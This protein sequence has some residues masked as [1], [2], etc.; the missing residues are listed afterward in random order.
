MELNPRGFKFKSILD[1]FT[2]DLLL[3][4]HE[5]LGD[6][7]VDMDGLK[8]HILMVLSD[9]PAQEISNT[10]K[11]SSS[12]SKQL[13]RPSYVKNL[14]FRDFSATKDALWHPF[15]LPASG[16]NPACNI[17]LHDEAINYLTRVLE[18]RLTLAQNLKD[19]PTNAHKLFASL[20]HHSECHTDWQL[21]KVQRH[22]DYQTAQE[23][24]LYFR[25]SAQRLAELRNKLGSGFGDISLRRREQY[26]PIWLVVD[27]C[28][29]EMPEE[30]SL[31][32]IISAL[33]LALHPE[34]MQDPE[35]QRGLVRVLDSLNERYKLLRSTGLKPNDWLPRTQPSI[36]VLRE[37]KK[38][39]TAAN[40][41]LKTG[42]TT[43]ILSAY[44]LAFDQTMITDQRKKLAGCTHFEQ[45]AQSEY[46]M[47]MLNYSALSLD[48]GQTQTDEALSLYEAIPGTDFEEEYLESLFSKF[49][50]PQDWVQY[51]IEIRPELFDEVMTIFFREV[52]AADHSLDL[53]SDK[54]SVL[55]DRSFRKLLHAHPYFK[56]LDESEWAEQ[57][58][59]QAAKII[60]KGIHLC[61]TQ[62][63]TDVQ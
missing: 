49:D 48:Q 62:G 6:N 4:L 33:P 25:N 55:K 60:E 1:N 58:V 44:R 43:T 53:V 21:A 46:G 9:V 2:W 26:G 39:R 41:I 40:E 52:I 51:L 47:N 27:A 15:H 18:R 38:L 42:E 57:L 20:S 13:R 45:F 24:I 50:Q 7:K 23:D 34:F 31:F 37:L 3:I 59:E 16:N 63:V 12:H 30:L 56:H 32:D 61:T 14:L 8:L 10:E 19:K 5:A 29:T 22:S 54:H 36:S 17:K 28:K 35:L 11:N